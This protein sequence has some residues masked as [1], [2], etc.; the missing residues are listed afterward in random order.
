MYILRGV[1]DL[2]GRITQMAK[3]S[4][5]KS[6]VAMKRRKKAATKKAGRRKK[7]AG[8]RRKKKK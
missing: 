8:G 5:M 1:S 6:K 3:K 7:K 4:K 2:T